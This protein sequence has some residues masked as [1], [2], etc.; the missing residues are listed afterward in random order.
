MGAFSSVISRSIA[1]K[2]VTFTLYYITFE[3]G[4]S[5]VSTWAGFAKT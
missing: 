1:S 5:G 4:M 3:G 2:E